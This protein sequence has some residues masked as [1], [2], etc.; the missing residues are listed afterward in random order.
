MNLEYFLTFKMDISKIEALGDDGFYIAGQDNNANWDQREISVVIDETSSIGAIIPST[1][2]FEVGVTGSVQYGA[3]SNI[4]VSEVDIG[5]L[6]TQTQ[7]ILLIH[8]LLFF[9][10]SQTILTDN[11]GNP[12][13][14][15]GQVKYAELGNGNLAVVWSVNNYNS[16]TGMHE[17]LQHFGRVFDPQPGANAIKFVTDEFR[18]FSDIQNGYISKIEALGDDGFYIAGQDYNANWDQRE[19]SVVIDETQALAQLF[20]LQIHLRWV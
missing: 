13:A 2:T 12:A 7:D 3:M 11:N 20:H 5:H 10:L 14:I 9:Q 17:G 19:I 4:T 16:D 1:N 8:G 18:I 6:M 15:S